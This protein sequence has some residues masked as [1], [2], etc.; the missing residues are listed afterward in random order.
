MNTLP[1]YEV[2]ID[3][4]D[5]PVVRAW[6]HSR[7]YSWHNTNESL[8][9]A[10]TED[11]YLF[12]DPYDKSVSASEAEYFLER[13]EPYFN[14]LEDEGSSN[15]KKVKDLK[16]GDV[17]YFSDTFSE[18]DWE[19]RHFVAATSTGIQ[20]HPVYDQAKER[21]WTKTYPGCMTIEE[22][23]AWKSGIKDKQPVY[24][25][26][27]TCFFASVLGFYDVR[28][29]CLFNLLTGR[30]DGNK[31]VQYDNYKIIPKEQIP[32][33]MLDEDLIAKLED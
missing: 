8:I 18:E 24:A 32:A 7:G 3:C 21:H 13:I 16:P 14:L 31:G 22:Y 29:K 27:N 23:Q 33:W 9:T 25:Y 30:R 4:G 11:K 15:M 17:A 19:L 26:D 1:D 10:H 5:N 6:L 2:K 20:A 12:V 28:G